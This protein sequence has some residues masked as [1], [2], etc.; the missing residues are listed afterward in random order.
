MMSSMRV[1]FVKGTFDCVLCSF[2]L[3][4]LTHLNPWKHV[5]QKYHIALRIFSIDV[6]LNISIA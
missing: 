4:Q 3:L 5:L 1:H 6:F 2:L